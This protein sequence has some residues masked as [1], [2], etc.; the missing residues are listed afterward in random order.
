MNYRFYTDKNYLLTDEGDVI[1]LK[2]IPKVLVCPIKAK[3]YRYFTVQGKQ[4]TVH[5]AI[6]TAFIGPRPQGFE[7][8]HKDGD[9]LNNR[10]D[11]LEYVTSSE[12]TMHAYELGLMKA[13]SGER[14]GKSRLTEIQVKEIRKMYSQGVRQA[15]LAK[16][17][18]YTEPGIWGIINYRTWK[19]V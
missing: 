1:S 11:N 8:N 10:V 17:F 14:S 2:G 19:Y 18:N 5:S 4:V 9:K 12:N 7:V 16:L 13:C 15:T 3:G 6:A